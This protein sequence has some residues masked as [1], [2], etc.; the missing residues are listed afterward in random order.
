MFIRIGTNNMIKLV[1]PH[2]SPP[3]T[4]CVL[5]YKQYITYDLNIR[6]LVNK[7]QYHIMSIN[8]VSDKPPYFIFIQ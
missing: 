5:A 8:T 1:R 6:K 4:R 7:P 2:E 3:N